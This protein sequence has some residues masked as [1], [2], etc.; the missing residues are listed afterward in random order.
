MAEVSRYTV[1]LP[2]R[3]EKDLEDVAEALQIPKSEAFR[4]ALTLLKHAAE[5]DEVI[6]KKGDHSTSVLLK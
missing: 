2:P 6:L 4:R 3:V 5:A 1:S